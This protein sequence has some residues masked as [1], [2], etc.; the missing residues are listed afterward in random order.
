[1]NKKVYASPQIQVVAL[2]SKQN[3]LCGSDTNGYDVETASIEYDFEYD[4][5]EY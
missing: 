4:D 3:M 5:E 1:M 2:T